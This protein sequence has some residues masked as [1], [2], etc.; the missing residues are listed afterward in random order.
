MSAET[1]NFL[2]VLAFA[3]VI[4]LIPAAIAH[5]KGRSFGIWWLFGAAVFI[6][7]LP[8][9]L[10]M[11]PDQEKTDRRKLDEGGRKCP[12]CA[13]IIRVEAIACRYCGRDSEPGA[14]TKQRKEPNNP[15]YIGTHNK[16][17]Y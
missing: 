12:H 7:A 1:W 16:D 4:G 6:V 14:R 8:V 13:E 9:A 3:A 2:N 10:V 15:L 5:K 11:S 17:L